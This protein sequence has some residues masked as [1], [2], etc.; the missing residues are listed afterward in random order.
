MAKTINIL[1]AILLLMACRSTRVATSNSTDS[2]RQS[3]SVKVVVKETIR[4]DTVKLAG[5]TVTVVQR[6]PCDTVLD[7]EGTN[8]GTNKPDTTKRGHVR[9]ILTSLG[10]GMQRID[11][12]A[13]SLEAV[14]A[15][16]DVEIT[17]L[18]QT[19]SENAK[20]TIVT[21]VIKKYRTPWWAYLAVTLW[22]LWIIKDL[23]PFIQ[24]FIRHR[25][26]D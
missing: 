18:Q 10:G 21:E 4:Y 5:G 8:Q 3:D 6:V 17:R 20:S 25:T 15:A 16:K 24:K 22:L 9:L 19:H 12:E 11:C 2:T 14:I 26:A 7:S 1:C 13:D 23:F